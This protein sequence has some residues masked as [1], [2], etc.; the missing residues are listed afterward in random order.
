MA[1]NGF[2]IIRDSHELKLPHYSHSSTGPYLY[3]SEAEMM[4]NVIASATGNP[5]RIYFISIERMLDEV[6]HFNTDWLI[7]SV[8]NVRTV[9]GCFEGEAII[10]G[11]R[12]TVRRTANKPWQVTAGLNTEQQPP[13]DRA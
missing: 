10:Q 2:F 8:W 6:V 7:T 5:C 9:D 4:A 1:V 3:R 11:K 13:K 12:Y